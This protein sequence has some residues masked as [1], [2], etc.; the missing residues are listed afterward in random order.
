M[1]KHPITNAQYKRFV[2]ATGYPEPAGEH[3]IDEKW[4]GPFH[5]WQHADF[6]DPMQ[7]VVCVNY[8]DVQQYIQWVNA[9]YRAGTVHLPTSEEWDIATFGTPYPS[10]DPRV[11]TQVSPEIHHSKAHPAV[12]DQNGA[13]A[14]SF[15]VTDLIGNIWEWTDIANLEYFPGIAIGRPPA[16]GAGEPQRPLPDLRG[17]SFLDNLQASPFFDAHR[18]SDRDATRHSDLGFRIAAEIRMTSLPDEVRERLEPNLIQE[19]AVGAFS[20]NIGIVIGSG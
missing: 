9:T 17:F 7:P 14:N 15:G 12:I 1:G 11:W 13:R 20:G 2:E 8:A 3:F 6:S 19:P 4:Q 16:L 10:R 5:P 18:L